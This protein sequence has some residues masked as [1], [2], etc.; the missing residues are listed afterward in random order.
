MAA[1]G[2][3]R[4]YAFVTSAVASYSGCRQYREDIVRAQAQTGTQAIEV[5]KLR[6]F[7]R[8]PGFLEPVTDAVRAALPHH[9]HAHGRV[10]QLR[11][12]VHVVAPRRE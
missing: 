12:E 3:R 5:L 1:D 11:R 2:I 6:T 8:H 4:V 10:W 9:V 7:S